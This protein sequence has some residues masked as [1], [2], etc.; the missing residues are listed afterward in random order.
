MGKVVNVELIQ[1][2]F[3]DILMQTFLYFIA[4]TV[5][6]EILALDVLTVV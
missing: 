5:S 3:W 2:S 4:I 1:S 6:V